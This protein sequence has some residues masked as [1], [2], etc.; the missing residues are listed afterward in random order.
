MTLSRKSVERS[1][2]RIFSGG[3]LEL[4]PKRQGDREMVLALGAWQLHDAGVAD[5]Q[6]INLLLESWLAGFCFSTLDRVTFRR[7]LV[8]EGFISR[9]RDGTRYWINTQKIHL[10]L[11]P[12]ALDVDPTLIFERETLEREARKHRYL[13]ARRRGTV[14]G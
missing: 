11:A 7:A 12:D 1:L 6:A 5:E 9:R 10:V 14:G 8:D 13:A 3:R 4:L 2:G